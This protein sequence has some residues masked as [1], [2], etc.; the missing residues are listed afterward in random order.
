MSH[1]GEQLVAP[2]GCGVLEKG[3]IYHYLGRYGAEAKTLFVYLD[4]KPGAYLVAM[5]C[6]EF[7]SA[8][9][10]ELILSVPNQVT[11][12]PWLNRLA[13]CDLA[14]LDEKRSPRKKSLGSRV[15]KRLAQ[16]Q[17]LVER[18]KE[19][20]AAEDPEYEINRVARN[21]KPPLNEGRARLWLLT[22]LAFGRDK[23]VLLP[24]YCNAGHWSRPGLHPQ[25]K[26][27]R[28]SMRKGKTHGH[29]L[30]ESMVKKIDEGYVEFGK[31]G[32]FMMTVWTKTLLK[33]FGCKVRTLGS[34]KKEFY[35]PTGEP[36][37]SFWQFRRTVLK[38]YGLEK[39]QLNLYGAARVRRTRSAS[40]GKF[41]EAVANLLERVEG[42]AYYLKEVPKGPRDGEPMPPLCVVRLRCMV[43]GMLVGIGFALGKERADAYRM[44]LF[45][46]ALPKD[47][48]CALFGLKIPKEDW[49]CEG[50][51]SWVT[52]DRGPGSAEDL[53]R[54][55]EQRI[56][57]REMAP[58]W[59]GQSKATIESSHPR[60][61]KFD[62]KPTFVQSELN[63][64]HLARREIRRT[65]R[66]NQRADASARMT[67]AMVQ[68]KTVPTPLGV[69]SYLDRRRRTDAH[70]MPFDTAVRN[71]LSRVEF[72]AEEDGVYLHGQRFD[73][74]AL[75]DTGLHGRVV[76]GGALKVSG[77]VL[78]LAVR[79]GWVE[80]DGKLA[81]VDALLPIRDF[82]GQLFL[83]LR[84][85][86][87][88]NQIRAEL[89]AGLHEHRAAVDA[90]AR[91]L[92]EEETGKS[93][94]A[95]RRKTG[96]AKRGTAAAR[97]EFADASRRISG[98]RCRA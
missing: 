40:K 9:D 56:P 64:V 60:D 61:V 47:E 1:I 41:S 71:F 68:A 19:L 96:R 18:I 94:D 88:I 84:E 55:L 51:P 10:A 82:E 11:V 83:S 89:R 70:P 91:E 65:V 14:A 43:S 63:Y 3:R 33:L 26:F 20:F 13:G 24:A 12:P 2:N 54:E 85:L 86:A 4:D 52:F 8:L 76:A 25:K 93:W 44:A 29:V 69:W 98:K 53:I 7:E 79:Q 87:E 75:R 92:F 49:P 35:H 39:V 97:Q 28:H 34:G 22:Y 42:D 62:G 72:S 17:P 57:V 95:G 30:T 5:K 37:P 74:D 16:I 50:L 15:D 80:I 23:W 78:D 38:K 66:D 36:F 90:E 58:S 73:S 59:E 46:M 27:G 48:F 81:R 6:T 32:V 67:P 77:Y 31:L 45:S 21:S